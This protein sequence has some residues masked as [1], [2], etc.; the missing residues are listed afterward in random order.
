MQKRISRF[1]A[2]RTVRVT[3]CRNHLAAQCRSLIANAGIGVSEV[4]PEISRKSHTA[5]EAGLLHDVGQVSPG[6]VRKP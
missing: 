4:V 3:T 6:H 5:L 1:F 2:G